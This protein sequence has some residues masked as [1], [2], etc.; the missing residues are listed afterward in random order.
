MRVFPLFFFK[1]SNFKYV[2]YADKN[3]TAEREKVIE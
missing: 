3:D 2:F 1:M